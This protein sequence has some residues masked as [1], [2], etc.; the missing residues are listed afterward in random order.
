MIQIVCFFYNEEAL[1]PFFLS[2]YRWADRIYA[3]VSK[4]QDRTRELL[5]AAPNVW[6][7][8]FE[9]P[10]GI[11]DVLKMQKA[12]EVLALRSYA[13]DWQLLVDADELLWPAGPEPVEQRIVS[14]R[15]YLESVP[16]T[17]TVLL[18]TMWNI[19]R[20]ATDAD[21]DPT[22]EPVALQRRHG[23]PTAE[24]HYKKPIVFRANRGV[25]LGVGNHVFEGRKFNVSTTHAFEG[26][27]WQNA[28]LSFAI[29][30]WIRDRRDH[31]SQNNK[32][33]GHGVHCFDMTPEHVTASA[34]SHLND[35]QVF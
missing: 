32:M 35:P 1:I 13:Y 12:H 22:R 19:Y 29:T 8:D 6:I 31:M 20:H 10:D 16:E 5:A 15:Q 34:Q 21:L 30:R 9:F 14:A 11:D 24:F 17:E 3:I 26:A 2:H 4:S 7:E 23:S 27:H 33:R 18:A 28:D 25:F